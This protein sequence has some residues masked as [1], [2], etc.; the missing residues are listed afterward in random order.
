MKR[1]EACGHKKPG[2]YESCSIVKRNYK[3]DKSTESLNAR[4]KMLKEE[5]N[6]YREALE[7][8]VDGGGQCWECV[9]CAQKA[10][11]RK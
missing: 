9:G 10:L 6:R 3:S 2:H 11:K 8:I 5:R 7:W 1:C 4:I